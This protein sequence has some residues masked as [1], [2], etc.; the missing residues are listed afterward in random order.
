M[1]FAEGNDYFPQHPLLGGFV[2]TIYFQI[3]KKQEL[4][5]PADPR[6]GETIISLI[7]QFF[8]QN[9]SGALFFIHDG[10]D[11]KALGR[12]KKFD[13]WFRKA[14]SSELRKENSVI[15]VGRVAIHTSLLFRQDHPML[16]ELIAAFEGM[17]DAVSTKPED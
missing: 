2:R 14:G 15:N 1:T 12:K 9:P 11:G 3:Q 17:G 6:V 13:V 10:S 4:R 16:T 8:E 5:I 7:L